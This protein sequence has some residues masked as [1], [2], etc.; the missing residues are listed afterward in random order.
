MAKRADVTS[1]DALESFR[2]SMLVYMEKTGLTLDEI[3]DAVKRTRVWVQTE[4]PAYW[5]QEIKRLSR[6]L[7]DAEQVLF[8]SR[9]SGL[10]EPSAQERMNVNRLRRAL[11]DAGEKLKTTKKWSR[12]YDGIVEPL[13]KKLDMLRFIITQSLP[14]GT[15]F[16]KQAADSLHAYAESAPGPKEGGERK[17]ETDAE[18]SAES[19]D[20]K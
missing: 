15:Q 6:A 5:R 11:R 18:D 10:R 2:S 4:Q 20:A 12:N 16:L 13:A 3:D 7:E 8:G 1:I 14:R 17:I 19:E 9:L